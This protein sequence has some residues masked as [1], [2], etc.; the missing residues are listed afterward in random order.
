MLNTR[1]IY[2]RQNRDEHDKAHNGP[3]IE[4]LIK[5]NK[6]YSKKY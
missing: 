4:F 6:D 1:L 3:G 5:T 2:K